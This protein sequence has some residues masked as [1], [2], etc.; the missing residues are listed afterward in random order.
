MGMVRLVFADLYLLGADH[1][2]GYPL[3]RCAWSFSFIDGVFNAAH[4][5]WVL[6]GVPLTI[7]QWPLALTNGIHD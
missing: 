7:S 4:W 1:R 3:D 6:G 2:F 5:P